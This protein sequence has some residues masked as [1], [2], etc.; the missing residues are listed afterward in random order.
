M[1]MN[2]K[3]GEVNQAMDGKMV[4]L[5]VMVFTLSLIGSL[6]LV[7]AGFTQEQKSF[8]WKVQS[9]VST[10]YVLGSIHFLKQGD[11]PL[12][13]RIDKAFDQSTALVVEANISDPG[14][15]NPQKLLE[16]ALYPENDS[17]ERH[18]STETYD[19]V[20]KETGNL[21]LPFELVNK[22]KPWFLALTLEALEL[23]KLGFDP[24]YGVDIY[25]LSKAQGTKKILELESLDEQID[26]LSNF[27]DREQEHFLLYTL[28]D[29]HVL[30]E[31]TSAIVKAWAS[32]NTSEIESVFT[33]SVKEDGR[34]APIFEKL[35]DNRNRKMISKIEGYLN[36]DGTYFVVVGA[37]HLVGNK[38]IIEILKGKGYTVEQL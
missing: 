30:G 28:K 17:L 22:Q 10:V 26:L 14:K 32:G 37:G 12:N 34:L 23:M 20:K 11:Y 31:Q 16:S 21:G 24:R 27:S 36:T 3:S 25:F 29:L 19:Y 1:V 9:K 8:L 18:V 33:K 5:S 2:D 13:P 38:G 35:I 4:R 15:L 7:P 6:V